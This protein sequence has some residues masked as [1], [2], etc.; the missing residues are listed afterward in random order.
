M[1]TLPVR[2]IASRVPQQDLIAIVTEVLCATNSLGAQGR[3]RKDLWLRVFASVSHLI[4]S[5]DHLCPRSSS[6]L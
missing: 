3:C 2:A 1:F 4:H 5:L 6:L